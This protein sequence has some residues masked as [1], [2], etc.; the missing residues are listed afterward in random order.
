[1]PKCFGVLAASLIAVSG[2]LL[3][4]VGGGSIVG[5]ITDPSRAV[6]AG[7]KVAALNS[8]T[9]QSTQTVTNESGFYEFPLLPPGR[10]RLSVVAEGF[11]RAETAEFDLNSGTRPRID[12]TLQLG[13]VA[14]SVAVQATAPLVNATT[15]DLGLVMENRRIEELPTNGRNFQQLVALQPGVVNM[16]STSAGGRGGIEF[17]GSS[18]LGNTFLLDGVDM[19]FGEVNALGDTAAGTGAGGALINT[20]SVEAIEQFKVTGSAFSAEYGR[21]TG[22]ILN[23]V[24]KSGSNRFHGT[25]YEFFRN[26]KLDANSFFSNRSGLARPPVRQNQYGANLSGPVLKDKLFFF[27][28]Y[29]GATVRRASQITGNVPTPLL[30]SQVQPQVRAALAGMPS[31]FTPTSNPLIGQHR[32]NDRRTNG[33]NTFLARGD[34]QRGKHRFASRYSYNHQDF[35]QPNL[36]RD[37]VREFPTRFHNAVLQDDYTIS[38]TWF[39]ALR[40]G[41]NRTLLNRLNSTFLTQPNGWISVPSLG[42]TSDDAK[43]IYFKN[44]AYTIADDM[45]V[46]RGRHTWKIG[47]EVRLLRTSRVNRDLTVHTFGNAN[48]LIANSPTTVRVTFGNPGR[49]LSSNQYG[50]YAQDEWRIS[51]RVQLNLGLRHEYFSPLAGAFNVATSDPF[52]PYAPSGTPMWDPDRNN[53]GPRAGLVVDLTGRQR[54]VLRVGSTVAH[55]PPQPIYYYVSSFVDPRLPFW[56]DFGR[57][58]VPAGFA[59][60]YPFPESLVQQIMGDPGRLPQGLLLGR[61]V[62]DRHLRDEYS[63]Q[64]NFSLQHAVTSTLSA[65]ASYVGS[66]GLKQF[67]A[68]APNQYLPGN[69]PRPRPDIGDVTF[70]TAEGRSSYHAL[71]LAVDQRPFHGATFG[72]YYT[73]SKVL[74]YGNADGTLNTADTTIQDPNNFAGSYGPKQGDTRHRAVSVFSYSVPPAP[75]GAHS[76]LVR[77]ILGGWSL[78]GILGLRSGLPV[79]VTAGVDFVGNRIV[80]GQRPDRV[81]AVDLYIHSADPLLWLNRAAFDNTAPQRERRFGNLGYNALRGP[82]GFTLDSG[83]HKSFLLREGHNLIV[84]VEAFNVFNHVVFSNPV[85]VV[86][87]PNFGTIQGGSGGRQLQLALKYRF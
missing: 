67:S 33:E 57:A 36:R 40:V 44:N 8:G 24:T 72:L 51:R 79:N 85:A 31:D 59:F 15:T 71:Q 76:R 10:Y 58:D 66:R 64:W 7:A 84:R 6:V 47:L 26:D 34:Y 27:F 68:R 56:T 42:L 86:T 75:L 48:D 60:S 73:Y 28:N 20:V 62:V 55:T 4:Q 30:L 53:F 80:A 23:V 12:V 69:G 16:P 5:T 1:M 18:S 9:N 82:G 50:F 81:S 2:P 14:E 45:T 13:A 54:T 11:T 17:N 65:Q 74:T 21:A 43:Q 29:E 61:N 39:N 3:G 63:G 35:T 77:G 37:N 19:S 32:R 46:V 52:G 38:P 78:Q 25:A 22:G 41:Y 83:V 70:Q 87:N 49:G